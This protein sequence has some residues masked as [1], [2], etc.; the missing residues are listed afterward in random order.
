MM[1]ID[2][3]IIEPIETTLNK[4][5]MIYNHDNSADIKYIRQHMVVLDNQDNM[6]HSILSNAK[7][8]NNEVCSTNYIRSKMVFG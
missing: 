3:N 5:S 8:I 1:K 2:K 7:I 6:Q 4:H